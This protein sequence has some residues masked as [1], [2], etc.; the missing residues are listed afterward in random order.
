V[1]ARS[2][3]RALPA[4]VDVDDVEVRD[5]AVYDRALGVA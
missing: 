4:P 5:L 2:A 1:T 3:L